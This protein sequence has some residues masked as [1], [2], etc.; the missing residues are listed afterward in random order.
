MFFIS[1]FARYC[2]RRVEPFSE[3]DCT[4]REEMQNKSSQTTLPDICSL[5]EEDGMGTNAGYMS[6]GDETLCHIEHA[7]LDKYDFL[8]ET[9]VV[10][11]RQS[12]AK[13][14]S[15]GAGLEMGNM[16]FTPTEAYDKATPTASAKGGLQVQAQINYIGINDA[17]VV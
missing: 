10:L 6:E 13:P 8:Q 15:R 11:P 17:T 1:L 14:Q 3:D 4:T 16:N 7:P 5:S 2:F 9:S 12:M